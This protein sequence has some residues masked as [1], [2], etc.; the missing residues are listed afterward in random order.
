TA[1]VPMFAFVSGAVNND[2]A[3]VLFSTMGVWWALRT[4]R[5]GD[6]SARGALLAGVVTGLGALSKS[7]ALGLVGL[8]ALAALFAFVRGRHTDGTVTL[9]RLPGA[10][11]IC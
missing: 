6:L 11:P 2:N 7:S 10:G 3:V 8:F 5:L 9:R 4:V 1:L